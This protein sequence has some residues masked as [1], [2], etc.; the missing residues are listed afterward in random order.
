MWV[1]SFSH[2][3]HTHAAKLNCHK[4][5]LCFL[6]SEME[7][8]IYFSFH[9]LQRCKMPWGLTKRFKTR[10]SFLWAQKW[11]L[12]VWLYVCVC[13]GASC[14]KRTR[15]KNPSM[16]FSR[17]TSALHKRTALCTISCFTQMPVG[18][19]MLPPEQ[20]RDVGQFL[21]SKNSSLHIF[22]FFWNTAL[23]FFKCLLL[24]TR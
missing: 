6:C 20:G 7:N 21:V 14:E 19:P 5:F 18:I 12:C 9:L 11:F 23:V 10:R 17:L 16:G 2:H 13:V 24:C 15:R 1:R 8:Y 22:T 3:F 4:M